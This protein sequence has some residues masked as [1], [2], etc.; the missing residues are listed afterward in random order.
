MMKSACHY[1]EVKKMIPVFRAPYP[2]EHVL[3]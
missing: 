1:W 3:G 2:D